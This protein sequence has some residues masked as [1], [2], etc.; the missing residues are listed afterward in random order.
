MISVGELLKK[1]R[2]KKMISLE[3]IAK[4]TKIRKKFLE[5]AE[6]NRWQTFPSYT[7]AL[8][9]VKVYGQTLKIDP[10]KVEAFFKREWQKEEKIRFKTP[11]SVRYLTSPTTSI[12]KLMTTFIILFIAGYFGYQIKLYLTPPKVE[13]ISPKNSIFPSYVKKITLEGKT[14]KESIVV[15]NGER[16]FLNKENKFISEIPLL[17]PQTEVVIEVTGANGKKTIVK[18]VFLKR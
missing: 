9:V 11:S 3:E 16:V 7:Y 12:L 18:K 4:K 1:E 2:Q 17:S 5:A 14:E 6:E 8:G 13:I 15:I 10:K